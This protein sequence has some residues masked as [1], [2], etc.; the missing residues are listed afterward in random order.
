M[1]QTLKDKL[2]EVQSEQEKEINLEASRKKELESDIKQLEEYVFKQYGKT[3]QDYN[4]K[5]YILK[6]NL[7]QY[8]KEEFS[9]L[10]KIEDFLEKQGAFCYGN[11]E[12]GELVWFFSFRDDYELAENFGFGK[13]TEITQEQFEI[14]KKSYTDWEKNKNKD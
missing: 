14:A 7:S 2:E 6:I 11:K 1:N 4:L 8:P 9:N 13:L 3:N 5:F 10:S 12:S